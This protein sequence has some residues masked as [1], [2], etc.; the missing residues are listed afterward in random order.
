MAHAMATMQ[1]SDI[2]SQIRRFLVEHFLSGRSENLRNDGSLL[3][4]VVDSLGVLDLVTFL[5]DRFKIAVEDEDVV[6]S[7]LDSV[8]N[9][10]SFVA[11]KLQAKN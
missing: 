4:N 1:T 5:Q 9:L 2:E 8:S 11:R 3:G 7:N 6:P 10:V